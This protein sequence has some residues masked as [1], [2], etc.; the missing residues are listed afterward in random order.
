MG[1]SATGSGPA[2]DLGDVPKPKNYNKP[3][4][5]TKHVENEPE[6]CCTKCQIPTNTT[7]PINKPTTVEIMNPNS[8]GES[9]GLNL[10]MESL[11]KDGYKCKTDNDG[12]VVVYLK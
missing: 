12:N 5:K 2:D 8:G 11:Q 4:Q 3:Y 6:P 7:E 1:N 10:L 9:K